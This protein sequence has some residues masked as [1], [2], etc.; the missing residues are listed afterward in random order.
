MTGSPKKNTIFLFKT[1][2]LSQ[3]PCGNRYERRK[4]TNIHIY[5]L[6]G[7]SSRRPV[8]TKTRNSFRGRPKQKDGKPTIID[9]QLVKLPDGRII[10]KKKC[11]ECGS[12]TIHLPRTDN[13]CSVAC[14]MQR[15]QR[16]KPKK[17]WG[18]TRKEGENIV[19]C[20]VCNDEVRDVFVYLESTHQVYAS[21][22]C[23]LH[24]RKEIE[25]L[26]ITVFLTRET[27][28][29]VKWTGEMWVDDKGRPLI[30]EAC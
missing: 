26:P 16:L 1:E 30:E 18:W 24:T 14:Q 19:K 20:P 7:M 5:Q 22:Y 12:P 8:W 3:G 13:F 28:R 9:E 23:E 10:V 21:S 4:M 29:I 25:E 15:K 6:Q 2:L 11:V 27:I 17:P